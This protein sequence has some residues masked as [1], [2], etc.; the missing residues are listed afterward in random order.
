MLLEIHKAVL[1]VPPGDDLVIVARETFGS[2]DA[3][4]AR[5][6]GVALAEAL[7]SHL[8]GATF[9][10][11]ARELRQWSDGDSDEGIT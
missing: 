5:N 9:L 4:S 11:L 7:R 2:D 10:S 8:P 3:E 6:E 1:T